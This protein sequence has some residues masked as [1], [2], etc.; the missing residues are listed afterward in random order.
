[1]ALRK[2]DLGDSDNV[3]ESYYDPDTQ[4][5]YVVFV[6]G[7]SGYYSGVP[8]EEAMAFEQADSHGKYLH[9]Y[10]KPRFPWV[11]GGV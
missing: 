1:M 4:R 3:S 6:S 5:L 8:E 11:R 7:G 9:Q 10:L 2:L